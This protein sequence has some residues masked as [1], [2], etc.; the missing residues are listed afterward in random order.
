MRPSVVCFAPLL[1]YTG[2]GSA[3]GEYLRRHVTALLSEY[4]VLVVAPGLDANVTAVEHEMPP[5]MRWRLVPTRYPRSGRAYQ[6]RKV[7]DALRGFT[8]GRDVEGE[9]VTD[10]EIAAAI[11][12]ATLVE[13]QWAH[14]ANLLFTAPDL[15]ADR[16][17]SLVVHDVYD[18]LWSRNH[19]LARGLRRLYTRLRRALA[20]R[21]ERRMFERVD[22]VL[23]LSDKDAALIRRIEPG[24][25][26]EVLDPPLGDDTAVAPPASLPG[27]AVLFTGAMGY[28]R[29]DEAARWFLREVWPT[30]ARAVPDAVFVVAGADPSES[31]RAVAEQDPRVVVTGYVDDLDSYYAASSVFVAPIFRGSGVKFKVITAMLQGV[32]VVATPVGA[33]GI[34]D[35]GK[36]AGITTDPAEFASAVIA[37]MDPDGDARARARVVQGWARDV[38]GAEGFRQTL[39]SAYSRVRSSPTAQR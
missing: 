25:W 14:S 32:P 37:A 33:E 19:E 18:Q 11:S 23:A 30:V 28:R 10:P 16:T 36:Y 5:G 2:I 12:E 8:L 9:I 26:V 27:H 24:A 13:F 22:L 7:V 39:L 31:L 38:Y 34:G 6:A 4:D 17:T 3:G 29:N 21:A 15:F 35:P 20:R 1:P